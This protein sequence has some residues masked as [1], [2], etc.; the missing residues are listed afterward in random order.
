MLR[1][2]EFMGVWR[3]KGQMKKALWVGGSPH[4]QAHKSL[5]GRKASA[6]TDVSVERHRDRVVGL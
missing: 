1:D 5:V 2:G 6:R 4:S 3:S